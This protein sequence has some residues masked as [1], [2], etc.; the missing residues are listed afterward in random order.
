MRTNLIVQDKGGCREVDCGEL[1]LRIGKRDDCGLVLDAPGV[2]RLHAVIFDDGG[3]LLVRDL[4]SANGT[5]RDGRLIQGDTPVPPGSLLELGQA[6]LLVSSPED[7]P[8]LPLVLAR[9]GPGRAGLEQVKQR[10]HHELVSGASGGVLDAATPEDVGRRVD[11]LVDHGCRGLALPLDRAKLVESVVAEA[12]GHGPLEAL[13]ADPQVREIMVNGPASIFVERLDGGLT[14]VDAAF[15][16][17]VHLLG[18]IRRIAAR[19]GREIHENQPLLDARLP[20]GSRFNAVIPPLAVYG[21]A[22]TIRKAPKARPGLSDLVKL[23]AMSPRLA[24]LLVGQVRERASLCVS[25]GTSSGKTTLLA[26]L[27]G[28]VPEPERLVTIEDVHELA[29][30]GRHLIALESRPAM[31]EGS[32]GTTIRQLVKNALRM[33]PDRIIVGECRGGEALDMLQAMNT[34]HDGS[35]TTLH[36][37]S[38]REGLLRLET[39]VL[40][41]DSGLPLEA[42][43]RQIG[44]GID[45]WIHLERDPDGAR[46]VAE[47][48]RIDHDGRD[49]A[50]EVIYR[51]ARDSAAE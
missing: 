20:D 12:L 23:G 42:I 25:G 31:H 6:R 19:A 39:L 47:V 48:A 17:E 45:L 37:N 1:P 8:P 28:V 22:V 7:A 43:R 35:M 50:C 18:V 32:A 40:Q 38:I 30:P 15:R 10:L 21:P 49:L 29:L 51:R 9:S 33:R 11:A 13:L 34:G 44:L 14:K 5:L 27:V 24:R 41:A 2:S 36:A 4:G 3:R 26:A 46:R 16:D